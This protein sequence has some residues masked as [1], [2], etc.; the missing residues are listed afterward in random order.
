MIRSKRIQALA[1]R[2]EVNLALWATISFFGLLPVA[3]ATSLALAQG[4][5]LF[6]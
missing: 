3:L 5:H 4:F 1:K 2:D 6:H